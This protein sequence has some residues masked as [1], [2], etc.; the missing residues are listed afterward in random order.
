MKTMKRT[1]ALVLALTLMLS[2]QLPA[3]AAHPFSDV[4]HDSWYRTAVEFVYDRKLMSGISDTIFGPDTNMTRAMLVTV[5]YSMEGKPAANGKLP[6]TDVAPNIWYRAPVAWAYANGIVSGTSA[7]S[8]S[9][10]NNITREQMV[11]IFSKYANFK[12][13][14][15]PPKASIED[16]ADAGTV[17]AYARNALS[18][19]VGN[20]IISGTS[21]ATL[22]P[23]GS[24]TRAQCAVI[25]MRFMEWTEGADGTPQVTPKP[26]PTPAPTPKPTPKPGQN[27]TPFA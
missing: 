14:D 2:M 1:L 16:Y 18:W 9:P 12:G 25:L 4:A 20:G 22:S 21:A 5:L 24:A 15:T 10:D 11:A 23:A 3:L 13:L 8:F 6:F 19:A 7:A 17:S 26:T 27:Q